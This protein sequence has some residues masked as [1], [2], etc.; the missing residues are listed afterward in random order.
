MRAKI[1]RLE[2]PL[3]L[4]LLHLDWQTRRRVT[5]RDLH[6]V[7]Q[8]YQIVIIIVEL[9]L[10]KHQWR[11]PHWPTKRVRNFFIEGEKTFCF[12]TLLC[13]IARCCGKVTF[14]SR[15]NELKSRAKFYSLPFLQ[16]AKTEEFFPAFPGRTCALF[17]IGEGWISLSRKDGTYRLQQG[18]NSIWKMSLFHE[19]AKRAKFKASSQN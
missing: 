3:G 16:C 13:I 9:L 10:D 4:V 8:S 6:L 2:T 17:C 15:K 12:W 18:Q 11:L 5:F 19:R 14:I 1:V 7:Y